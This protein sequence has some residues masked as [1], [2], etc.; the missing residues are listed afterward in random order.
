VSELVVKVAIPFVITPLPRTVLPSIKVT[1]PVVPVG[2]VAVNVTGCVVVEGFEE[3]VSVTLE[4][5][6]KTV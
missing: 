5:F 1:V 3:E 4:V 6:F 2:S